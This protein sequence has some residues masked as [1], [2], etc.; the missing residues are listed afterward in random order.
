VVYQSNAIVVNVFL[1]FPE[2][3]LVNAMQITD[4]MLIIIYLIDTKKNRNVTT[5][6]CRN[7]ESGG[8]VL[9]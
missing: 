5:N 2:Y 3:A 7:M 4:I 8:G 6:A 1:V 9:P